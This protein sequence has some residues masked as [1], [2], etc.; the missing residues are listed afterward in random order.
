MTKHILRYYELANSA[1]VEF[2]LRW[3]QEAHEQAVKLSKVYRIPVEIIC[4][5]IA[6]LSPRCVWEGN[7]LN[8]EK[9]L[10]AHIGHRR[11]DSFTVTTYGTNKRKAW[12]ILRTGDVEL[13]SGLKVKSFYDNILHPET[14]KGVTI[15]GHAVNIFFGKVGVVKNKHFQPA[16]YEKIAKVYVKISMKLGLKPLELQAITWLCYKRVHGIRCNWRLYQQELPF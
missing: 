3:Y 12:A 9:M 14:S 4:A 8:A 10:K 5:V 16:W 7:L 6:G 1:E 11:L 15:D 2:G 13:L